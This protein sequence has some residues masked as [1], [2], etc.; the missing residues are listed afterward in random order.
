MSQV[1]TPPRESYPSFSSLQGQGG[2]PPRSLLAQTLR[3]TAILVGACILFVGLLS[4]GAVLITSKA[5]G[6]S[7]SSSSTEASG[8]ESSPKKS[9]SSRSQA[10]QTGQAGLSL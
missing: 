9:D 4:A 7:P 8:K 3:T 5:V 1:P 10:S 6:A 2:P